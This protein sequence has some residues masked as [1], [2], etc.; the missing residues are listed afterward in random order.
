MRCCAAIELLESPAREAS[1][2]RRAQLDVFRGRAAAVVAG[3][4]RS[5]DIVEIPFGDR[6]VGIAFDV[7]ELEAARVDVEQLTKA[8]ARTLDQLTTAVAIFDRRKQ[9][10]LP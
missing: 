5:L 8:H 10:G 7:S 3:W 1:A 2:A 9:T 6:S 4:R